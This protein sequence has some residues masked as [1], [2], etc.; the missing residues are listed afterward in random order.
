MLRAKGQVESLT[1][2]YS[3]KSQQD[4]DV[5]RPPVSVC[6]LLPINTLQGKNSGVC[7]TLWGTS[8]A[9]LDSSNS[10]QCSSCVS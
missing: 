7:K 5:A 10:L 6:L 2:Q 3:Q 4:G 9:K 1:L 8:S